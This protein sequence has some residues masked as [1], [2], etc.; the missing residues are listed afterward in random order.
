MNRNLTL[1]LGVGIFLTLNTFAGQPT[2]EWSGQGTRVEE[3]L[4]GKGVVLEGDDRLTTPDMFRPP[5]EITI[6]A[7][8]EPTDLRVA[9]AADQVIFNWGD[10]EDQLRVD[11]GPANGH[12]LDGAGRI[13]ADKYVTIKWV[14]TPEHQ[15]IYVDDKLRFEHCGNYAELN[16]PVSI[17][18][19]GA[20]KVTVKSIKVK[21]Q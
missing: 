16:R 8:A 1:I 17:F 11:G 6:V 5:V 2:V 3:L 21:Q 15:A 10:N 7:K 12:H 4:A 18:S 14:A 20:S 9:Y 19:A 13:P